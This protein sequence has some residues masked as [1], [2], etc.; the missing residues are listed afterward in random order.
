MK[1]FETRLGALEIVRAKRG[2]RLLTK[3]QRDERVEHMLRYGDREELLAAAQL[4][5]PGITGSPEQRVAAVKVAFQSWDWKQS[6]A[7]KCGT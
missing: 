1:S 2:V 5:T 6:Q 4:P 3:K 7:A